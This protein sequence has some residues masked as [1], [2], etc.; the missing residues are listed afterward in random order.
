MTDLN[1]HRTV[2]QIDLEIYKI[3]NANTTS[4]FLK[5]TLEKALTRDPIGVANDLEIALMLFNHRLG[6]VF[7]ES[8]TPSPRIECAE[9]V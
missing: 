2:Q 4:T 3:I 7:L 1:K 5:V 6:A 8:E 9:L